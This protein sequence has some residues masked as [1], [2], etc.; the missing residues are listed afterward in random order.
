[1]VMMA[2]FFFISFNLFVCLFF[3]IL[4]HLCS[5]LALDDDEMTKLTNRTI[6]WSFFSGS[7]IISPVDL[8]FFFCKFQFEW[9]WWLRLKN[10][11]LFFFAAFIII[12]AS[13]N[14]FE[15]LKAET[16]SIHFLWCF[17]LQVVIKHM[18]TKIERWISW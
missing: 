3:I 12:L 9:W 15:Y 16:E 10:F 11:G 13:M 2:S 6:I 14:H 18:S 8:N 5:S 17:F 4:N 7:L 1:M